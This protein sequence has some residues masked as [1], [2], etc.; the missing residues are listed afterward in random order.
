MSS[1]RLTIEEEW[2]DA[3]Q[4]GG[5][6][7]L[8]PRGLQQHVDLADMASH[9]R[10]KLPRDAW[11]GIIVTVAVAIAGAGSAP[12][13]WPRS[14]L[15]QPASAIVGMSG[16]CAPFQVF[17]QNRWAPVGT[18]IRAA[19]NV[20]S[21]QVGSF[22]A[23]M[24]ISINGWAYGRPAYPTDTAPWNSDVWF[25]LADGAGWVS[26]P[27]VRATPVANDPTGTSPDGGTPAPTSSTC[28]G[29]IQ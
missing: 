4:L 2:S 6:N 3:M 11:I 25:H 17:A 14:H 29:A 7:W 5:A 27:G 12:W 28:G 1:I 21:E 26:F 19:P 16:G 18:A 13:W 10:L 24:S 8:S 20:Q 9:R 15:Q 23:N 22:P